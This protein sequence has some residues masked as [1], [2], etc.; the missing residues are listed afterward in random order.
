LVACLQFS[1]E[2]DHCDE[3][4]CHGGSVNSEATGRAL[5]A[6]AQNSLRRCGDFRIRAC[7][8]PTI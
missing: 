3:Q 4:D 8:K 5:F 7:V 6:F 1:G 2:V